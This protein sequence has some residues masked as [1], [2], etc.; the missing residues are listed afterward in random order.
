MK[1]G[2][3]GV[4][5]AASL[6]VTAPLAQAAVEPA[7][8]SGFQ[9]DTEGWTS[10]GADCSLLGGTGLLCTAENTH[11]PD[12]GNPDGALRSRT[13]VVVNALG[14][15]ESEATWRSPSFTVGTPDEATFSYDRRF[16]AGSLLA[17]GVGAESEVTLVDEGDGSRT[18]VVNEPLD[19][20]DATYATRRVG[21]DT[22]ELN[23]GTYHLEVAVRART[24][25]TQADVLG[26]A[27]FDF[28]N[29]ALELVDS[30]KG[31]SDGVIT[32]PPLSDREIDEVISGLDLDALEGKFPGGSLVGP[33]DCTITGTSGDDRIA[34]TKGNDVICGMGG[35]DTISGGSGRDV[36]DTGNGS[37]R[38]G[39]G[40]DGDYVL[41]LVGKDRLNGSRGKDSVSG[42]RGKDRLRGSAGNDR[43]FARDGARDRINGGKGNRDHAKIDSKDR[44]K[45]VQRT[46]R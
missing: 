32:D 6:F 21:V 12:G 22:G 23:R 42:G 15:I 45:K 38:A 8:G 35:N 4:M 37:D 33:K 5:C 3:I 43:H 18:E 39:A 14:L 44:V 27:A 7:G 2:L 10:L 1:Q 11:A 16:E 34:G 30:S 29:V 19:S 25:T 17:L 36:I 40:P 24:T 26:S 46:L 20:D 41:G 31:S 9:A 13:Q 28:D